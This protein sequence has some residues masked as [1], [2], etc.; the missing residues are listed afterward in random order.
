MQSKKNFINKIKSISNI[1]IKQNNA[2][3]FL[4]KKYLYIQL[5][6]IFLVAKSY[7]MPIQLINLIFYLE[8]KKKINYYLFDYTCKYYDNDY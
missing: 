3:F 1:G 4:L 8:D 7:F 6:Y 2:T 5:Y